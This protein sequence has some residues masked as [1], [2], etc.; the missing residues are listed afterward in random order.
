[1]SP[2]ITHHSS[3]IIL[4]GFV[5]ALLV[6]PFQ[7]PDEPNHFFR[8]WQVSEGVFF[9][10]KVDN[11]LGGT[12]P[13]SLS[14]V[15]DSFLFLKNN[16]NGRLHFSTL[17]A[18]L[19]IPLDTEK[20]HFADF[21]NTAIYAPTAYIPQAA[22]IAVF[23]PLGATPLQL[24]YAA[25]IANLLVW[26][27]LVSAALRLLPFLRTA[28]AA[29]AILPATLCIA[30]TANADVLT[31][32]LS[33]FLT[34]ALLAKPTATLFTEKL[35]P[36]VLISAHKLIAVP[37]LLLGFLGSLD[38]RRA[39]LLCLAGVLAALFWSRLAQQWFIPY[40]MY[41]PAFRDTQTLNSGVDPARQM[42][43]VLENP[44]FFLKT[45]GQ[46]LFQALPSMAAH[47][48]GKFGWEKNYLPGYWILLLWIMLA[49]LIFSEKTTLSVRQRMGMSGIFLLYVGAFALAMYAL[50]HGVGAGQISNWQARYFMPVVPLA[51][52]CL[53]SGFFE[54]WKSKIDLFALAVLVLGN[55]A[56]AWSIWQ[57][58][59]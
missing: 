22:A 29:I 31:N 33:W 28:L 20:R 40:D 34:A 51:A 14:Q 35:L 16:S 38:R 7:S 56:M 30:A 53:A 15:R 32:G 27:L 48:V 57:H 54:K 44:V 41:N 9:P 1:M 49:A 36:A 2:L 12:L 5:F 46:S 24:L 39:T 45:C 10:E 18:A 37:L 58:Y 6:P 47:F 21:A 13:V 19:A 11:R 50:W 42:A 4:F 3:F 17:C 26:M 8:A 23:R 52:L 59:W 25:R 43:F 55:A